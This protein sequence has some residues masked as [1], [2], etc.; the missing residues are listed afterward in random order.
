MV[1]ALT[2]L[3]AAAR[4]A[5]GAGSAYTAI[6]RLVA[7][8]TA[9]ETLKKKK[10]KPG[11]KALKKGL[12][13]IAREKQAI[14]DDFLFDQYAYDW[15]LSR[16]FLVF[17][18]A[19]VELEAARIDI[20]RSNFRS[21]HVKKAL[22]CL[23]S[24]RAGFTNGQKAPPELDTQLGE[25]NKSVQD[26]INR[27]TAI[28]NEQKGGD[29]APPGTANKKK[30]GKEIQGLKQRKFRFISDWFNGGNAKAEKA[31]SIF[32]VPFI[33]WFDNLDEVDQALVRAGAAKNRK[34]VGKKLGKAIIA[35]DSLLTYMRNVE[36]GRGQL[37]HLRQGRGVDPDLRLPQGPGR[38]EGEGDP[39][40]GGRDHASEPSRLHAERPGERH[41][42]LRR[43]G[44]LRPLRHLDRAPA[45]GRGHDDRGRRHHRSGGRPGRRHRP[46]RRGRIRHA[47]L[48][49]ALGAQ[50][51]SSTGR[52]VAT[53]FR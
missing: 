35:K 25:L 39:C 21:E 20:S 9:L 2:A 40:G 23:Q 41:G 5:A 30:L 31:P 18:C 15:Q 50:A 16:A 43:P 7:L 22:E 3:L 19:D 52:R 12:T 44:G 46:A 45:P 11:S 4:P 51:G 1:L 36:P 38:P 8:D 53:V 42:E 24:A 17:D 29:K 48:P 13:A 6:D 49:E 34:I 26:L 10:P 47:A 14:V 37:R 27:L 33:V 28:E 32:G